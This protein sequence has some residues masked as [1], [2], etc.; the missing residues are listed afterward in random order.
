MN[1]GRRELGIGVTLVGIVLWTAALVFDRSAVAIILA[2]AVFLVGGA[3]MVAGERRQ[4]A[5]DV[6]R[7]ETP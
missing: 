6:D 5:T 1:V 2:I 3:L 7:T 4:E